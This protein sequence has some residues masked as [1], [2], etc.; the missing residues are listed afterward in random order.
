ML[1]RDIEYNDSDKMRFDAFYLLL[2]STYG[3]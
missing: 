1:I 3:S 2:N